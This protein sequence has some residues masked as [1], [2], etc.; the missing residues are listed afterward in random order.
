MLLE[1]QEKTGYPK[2]ITPK[3]Q[4]DLTKQLL[5][6]RMEDAKDERWENVKILMRGL[7]F[8]NKNLQPLHMMP[9]L[10]LDPE[11]LEQPLYR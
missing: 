3:M 9:K 5:E 2:E 1:Q 6:K 7:H 8:V 10:E 4:E 11:L